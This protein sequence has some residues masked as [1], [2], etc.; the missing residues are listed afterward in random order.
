MVTQPEPTRHIQVRSENNVRIGP[1][2]LITMIIVICMAVMGVLAISTA[3]ATHTISDRQANATRNLYDNERAAQEFLASLDDALSD[4]RSGGSSAEAGARVVEARLDT[5][6]ENARAAADGKVSCTAS[7]D[8]TVVSAEFVC[9]DTRLLN[10][11]VTILGSG[12]YRVDAWKMTSA[13]G[14]GPTTGALWTG[15]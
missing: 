2:T 4:V 8:G 13:Q 6:C 14:D 12:A 11:A 15:E 10:I 7:V 3:Q 1:I 9:E 5:L